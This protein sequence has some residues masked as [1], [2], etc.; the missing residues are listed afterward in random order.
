MVYVI[1]ANTCL[2]SNRNSPVNKPVLLTLWALRLH[3]VINN[4]GSGGG[5]GS[6]VWFSIMWEV[7]CC[8][9]CWFFPLPT[10]TATAFGTR[11]RALLPPAVRAQPP[12]LLG[13]GQEW[14]RKECCQM[15]VK[16]CCATLLQSQGMMPKLL[17]GSMYVA[18][19]RRDLK[20]AHMCLPADAVRSQWITMFVVM[21]KSL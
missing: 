9:L 11:R 4:P 14:R 2:P 10:A 5:W 15:N 3:L 17:I 18:C 8:S 16:L 19:D 20:W 7:A 1:S 12:C 6:G 13:M 21:V